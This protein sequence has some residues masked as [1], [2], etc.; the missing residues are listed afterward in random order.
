MASPMS[1]VEGAWALPLTISAAGTSS[2][3]LATT[4]R[5][6]DKDIRV[7]TTTPAAVFGVTDNKVYCTTGGFVA[8]NA[9]TAVGTV[10]AGTITSGAA[11]ISSATYT[12]NSSTG[13]FGVSGSATV[14]APSVGTAGYVSSSVGTKNTNT[15]TLST[16][17]NKIVGSTAL[18]MD[19]GNPTKVPSISKQT[20]S[21]TGVTDAASGSST[22]TA[23]SSGVY[24]AVK[25]AANTGTITATPSV[26]T[27]GYGTAANH[28]IESNSETVGAAESA[29]T[30][31]PIKT[32]GTAT[33]SV[34]AISGSSEVSVGTKDASDY[35]PLTANNV[36]VTGNVS[37]ASAG[38]FTG[39]TGLTDSDTDGVVI[40]KMKEAGSSVSAGSI[41]GSVTS[42]SYAYNSTN[43][44]YDVTGSKSVSGTATVTM[45]AGYQ[46]AGTI[47]AGSSGTVSVA[48]TAAKIA[49]KATLSGT[50][51]VTPTLSKVT[52][53]SGNSATNITGSVGS[54]TT[55]KPT[56]GYY[57]AA[58]SG[59]A[60]NTVTATPTVTS[61]GYGTTTSGQYGATNDTMSVGANDSADT[62]FSVDAAAVTV[63]GTNTVSPTA[64]LSSSNVTLSDSNNGISVTATG[65]G[66]ASV[67][68]AAN[69]T[70]AGYIPAGNSFATGALNAASNTTTAIKYISA[71][72]V[73]SSKAL[74]VTNNGTL[75]LTNAS[76][77]TTNM[78]NAG[79]TTITSSSTSSGSVTIAA[80]TAAGDA[81]NTSKEV[82]SGG[83]WKTT[84]ASGAN[85]YYGRVTVG[86]VSGSIGGSASGGSATAAIANTNSMNTITTLT[87]LTAGTDYWQV[88][89]TATG[90]AG[91]YTP[92]YTVS[93]AGWIAS[94][95]TGT[96]QTVSV[97][98]DSTGQS[99]Y[100]PKATFTVSGSA[101]TVATAG[102]IPAGTSVTNIDAGSI[103]A[104]SSDPG[105][106]YTEKTASDGVAISS[107]GWLKIN[108]G[109]FGNT[110][111]S[112]AT[113]IGDDQ[114]ILPVSSGQS[115]ALRSGYT[116]YDDA[117]HLVSGTIVDYDGSYTVS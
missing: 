73:P 104:V 116:A 81:S 39:K 47:S 32:A 56:S 55:T 103:T 5:F 83:L 7:T 84:A 2:Y 1:I 61:A 3:L 24:V 106:S 94:T 92:K 82:V 98:S 102:Y 27:A 34:T 91:S 38:W 85:T 6:L 11:T 36:S 59:G 9:E 49:I 86:A 63:T 108:A 51:K 87:G 74:T 19:S 117:G 10:G 12:Y 16:T 20:I 76:G 48:G 79:T 105:S 37:L 50:A 99:L 52:T 71:V 41:S 13:K 57:V 22:T 14:A 96:A 88:K 93:T 107:G 21:I 42:L 64:S 114:S 109:Y 75:T 4:N 33:L 44:N 110:K 70:T 35:Y 8:A 65:G 28:G 67:T 95:V 62:Y 31:V 18:A 29:M 100:I 15:A 72:T 26:T 97:S 23:P 46:P 30:Y 112:L 58:K 66:T 45:T 101:V 53:A 90:S 43:G 115:S 113:L 60:T 78:S 54:A 25:S 111:I 68:A 77:A 89:A 17:V 69:V 40:G 80:K